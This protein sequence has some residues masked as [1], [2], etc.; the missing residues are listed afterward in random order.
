MKFEYGGESPS[1]HDDEEIRT[2][3]VKDQ[4]KKDL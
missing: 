4:Q 2:S 1:I 3:K